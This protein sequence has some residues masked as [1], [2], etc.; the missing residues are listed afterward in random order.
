MS[1]APAGAGIHAFLGVRPQASGLPWHFPSGCGTVG[2]KSMA[3][4]ACF[5]VGEHCCQ[6]TWSRR[7]YSD[8]RFCWAVSSD[9]LQMRLYLQPHPIPVTAGTRNSRPTEW[10]SPQAIMS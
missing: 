1:A 6:P 9:S 10:A 5:P 2:S 4:P 3:E 8:F 7:E